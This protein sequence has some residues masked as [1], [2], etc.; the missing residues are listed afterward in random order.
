MPTCVAILPAA[1]SGSRFGS[2][3]PK[4]FTLLGQDM[5]VVHTL[6]ALLQEPR[7]QKIHVVLDP[8][9]QNLIS[10]SQWQ[11]RVQPCPGA[12]ASRAETVRNAVEHLRQHY[13]ADTWVL[14]HDAARPCVSASALARLLDTLWN[15]PVGGL[16]AIPVADTLKRQDPTLR[17]LTT[18]DRSGLWAAQTPQMFPLQLL[19]E[20]LQRVSSLEQVTDEASAIEAMGLQ[21]LLVM[22]EST[23]IKVTYPADQRL[24]QWLLFQGQSEM[25]RVSNRLHEETL[26]HPGWCDERHDPDGLDG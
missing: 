2:A 12:G 15:D 1:G 6:R 3:L 11:G 24:A 23:N 13:S 26:S 8:E 9:H 22:G 16:L 20:A 14:V 25:A 21:P 18:V 10:W 5:L 19:A 4:Q 17:V 7:I